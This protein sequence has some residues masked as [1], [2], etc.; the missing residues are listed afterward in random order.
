MLSHQ[1]RE[2]LEQVWHPTVQAG[3]KE[4]AEA[5][6]TSG[7]AKVIHLLPCGKD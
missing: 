2:A 5:P 6:S 4:G 1:R 7:F 3:D